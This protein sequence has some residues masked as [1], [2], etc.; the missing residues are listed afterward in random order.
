MENSEESYDIYDVF[1]LEK[2]EQIS[3]LGSNNASEQDRGVTATL[4]ITINIPHRWKKY[5]QMSV[6]EQVQVYRNLWADMLGS[7]VEGGQ[8]DDRYEIEF[9]RDGFPHLHGYI[10]YTDLSAHYPEGL[11]KD[12]VR[13]IYKQL[14]KQ[15]WKQTGLPYDPHLFR[16]RSPCV[17]INYKRILYDNWVNYMEKTRVQNPENII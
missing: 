5:S 12:H 4:E 11:V 7:A 6:P 10:K 17:C 3:P 13:A 15:Y 8:K 14:P 2:S 16:F 9:C 1:D